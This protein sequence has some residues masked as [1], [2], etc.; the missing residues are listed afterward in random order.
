LPVTLTETDDRSL[1]GTKPS[2]D[3][4]NY[5]P[6][7]LQHN[8]PRSGLPYFNTALF[9][10]E[11]LG[12]IGNSGRRFFSGPGINNWDMALLKET[13][14]TESTKLQFRL[15]MFNVFNHAS[16]DTPPEGNINSSTF[17]YVTTAGDP[18]IGQLALKFL[19]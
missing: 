13:T 8:N 3:L 14:I 15:E 7:N 11:T 1:I 5:T 9:S 4:P 6:G 16:F 19:F 2:L 10:P 12:Q 18:R 17:G